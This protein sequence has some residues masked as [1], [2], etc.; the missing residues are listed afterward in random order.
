M[1]DRVPPLAASDES[2]STFFDKVSWS[3]ESLSPLFFI[4]W[5][6]LFKESKIPCWVGLGAFQEDNSESNYFRRSFTFA[7]QLSIS[8]ASDL[9]WGRAFL[10]SY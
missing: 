6:S 10:T 2:V 3:P 8:V 7:N 9:R 5:S 1:S 4:D